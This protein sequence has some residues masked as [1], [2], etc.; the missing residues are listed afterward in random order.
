VSGR[1]AIEKSLDTFSQASRISSGIAAQMAD[2]A[3]Q[4]RL[5]GDYSMV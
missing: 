5:Y 2:A 4:H 3:L 1:H